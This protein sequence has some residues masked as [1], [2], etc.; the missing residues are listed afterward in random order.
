VDDLADA[1]PHAQQVAAML[2]RAP[3]DLRVVDSIGRRRKTKRVAELIEED[4]DPRR[5]LDLARRR[6]GPRSYAR[7]RALEDGVSI[8]ADELV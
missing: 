5:E 6:R 2:A 1:E 7:P 8:G 4:G 3:G